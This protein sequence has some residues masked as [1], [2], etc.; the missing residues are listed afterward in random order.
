MNDEE[1]N[2]VPDEKCNVFEWK[3][4]IKCIHDEFKSE[5][6]TGAKMFCGSYKHRF[7]KREVQ[8]GAVPH[9]IGDALTRRKQ[10]K[11]L[12]KKLDKG[13]EQYQILDKR[14][15]ALKVMA[16]SMY[17]FMGAP[18]GYLYFVE[19]A[20]TVTYMG[21]E[22]IKRVQQENKN[23]TIVYGDSVTKDTPIITK[24]NDGVHICEIQDLVTIGNHM[25]NL[26]RRTCQ[27][28]K[29]NNKD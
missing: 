9:I 20:M 23:L 17:G 24:D 12:M 15:S 13:D 2:D 1:K 21:R 18:R 29:K 27:I 3:E 28:E 11:E 14:Q 6:E 25:M 10:T 5:R 19:G 16:N 7:L 8:E 26:N 22:S 4:H